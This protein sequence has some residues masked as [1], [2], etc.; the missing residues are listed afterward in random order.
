MDS[1]PKF[2]TSAFVIIIAVFIGISLIIA[3]SSVVSARTF[4]SGVADAIGSVDAV[5]EEDIIEECTLLAKENGY[6]LKTEKT[7]TDS[8][9]YYEVILEYQFAAPF[10]GTVHTGTVSG[11]VYP[12]THLNVS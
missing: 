8:E 1:I 7:V 5:Y 12:G 11:Y 2:I 4:Y 10:F 9:Y 3:G 6:A